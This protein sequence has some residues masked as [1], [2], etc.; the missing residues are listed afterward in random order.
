M[1]SEAPVS[2]VCDEC[3]ERY[4]SLSQH[5]RQNPCCA[6][7]NLVSDSD[8]DDG[9]DTDTYSPR[10]YRETLESTGKPSAG[11]TA[12]IAMDLATL[13][14]NLDIGREDMRV[15]KQTVQEWFDQDRMEVSLALQP[16][17]K[18]G[19]SV[20]SIQAT[21]ARDMFAGISTDKLERAK[22]KELAPV[23]E[24]REVHLSDERGDTVVSFRVADLIERRLQHDPAFRR[25]VLE[26]SEY[27]K[28]GV[29]YCTP[30][31]ELKDIDACAK[32]RYHAKL[33]RPAQPG[34]DHHVRM[35]GLFNAD[36][37]EVKGVPRA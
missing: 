2:F 20:E 21:M 32:G 10:R 29:D 27:Y 35:C 13:R 31:T 25:R 19:K 14:N 5:L 3:E 23:V 16:D 12:R 7:P 8:S 1:T 22:V 24:P 37:V 33:H 26:R 30:P 9:D 18:A 11:L 28:S 36:D 17:M 4:I 15:L 34:E 6:H